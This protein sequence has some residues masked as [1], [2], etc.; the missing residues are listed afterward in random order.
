MSLLIAGLV[1]ASASILLAPFAASPAPAPD[2]PAVDD[3]P[4]IKELPD[5]FLFSDGSRVKTKEDWA[6]RR[7][8]LKG[9]ILYY[10]YGRLPPAPTNLAA[11]ELSSKPRATLGVTEKQVQLT[12]GPEGA[13]KFKLIVSIPTGKTGLRPGVAGLRPG[14]AGHA[15][16][17]QGRPVLGPRARCRHPRC[18]LARVH[19]G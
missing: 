13:V 10:E 3:L 6:R 5:L 15:G 4:V 18:R 17:H 11:K 14:E 12:M 2:R 9:L 8:E 16:H 19:P 1:L 7:E